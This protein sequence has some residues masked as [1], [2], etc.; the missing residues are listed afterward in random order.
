MNFFQSTIEIIKF[1]FKKNIIFSI[2]M[3][4]YP[5]YILLKHEAFI[6][7]PQSAIFLAISICIIHIYSLYDN[8]KNQ[9][10]FKMFGQYNKNF[11]IEPVQISWDINYLLVLIILSSSIVLAFISVDIGLIIALSYV[12]WFSWWI[13]CIVRSYYVEYTKLTKQFF[14]AFIDGHIRGDNEKHEEKNKGDGGSEKK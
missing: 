12:L 3:F 14:R 13:M 6:V 10:I 1:G 5:L 11:N 9:N 4:F 2:F 8:R 7:L